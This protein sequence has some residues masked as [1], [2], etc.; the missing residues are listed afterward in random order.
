VWTGDR[1]LEESAAH[2]RGVVTALFKARWFI[3]AWMI[4]WAAIGLGYVMSVKG[5]FLA[6]VDILLEPRHIANDGPE[7]L[8]HF[9]QMALDSEQ[10]DTELR[11]LRSESLLRPVF[12]QLGFAKAPELTNGRDGF[13]SLLAH[14]L[15]RLAPRAVPYEAHSRAFYA[16]VDRVRCLRVGDSYVIE[17]TYRSR[18]AATAAHVANAVATAYVGD[19][20]KR[21]Q[22]HMERI[23][24]A[25]LLTRA[26]AIVTRIEETRAAVGKGVPP[27]DDIGYGDVRL[28]GAA[29]PPLAKSYPKTAPTLLFAIGFGAISAVALVLFSAARHLVPMTKAPGE[30]EAEWAPMQRAGRAG[31]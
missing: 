15:H 5:E 20:L 9:H 13:W 1:S 7:D 3:I 18:S 23:G 2:V 6:K 16:F 30:I 27:G 25:Y 19:R 4:L 24:G 11:V 22:A 14:E 31:V 10:A 26:E 8:R 29:V 21:I 17:L 28:L 12:D